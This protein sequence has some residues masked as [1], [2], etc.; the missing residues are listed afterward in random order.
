MLLRA[1]LVP[2]FLAVVADPT[3][4]RVEVDTRETPDLAPWGEQARELVRQWH[5]KISEVLAS[6]GFRPPEEVKIVFK[7]ARKGVAATSGSTITITADW[8][9]KHPDDFGMVVHE[10]THVIQH[11]PPNKANAGWLV[12]GIADHVRCFH[13]EPEKRLPPIDVKKASYRDGYKTAARFLDWVQTK[14]DPRLVSRLNA[15]LR[16]GR[17]HDKLFDEYTGKPLDELWSEFIAAA[18]SSRNP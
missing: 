14:Y 17:Y 16:G 7:D 4:P 2:L 9:R 18:A 11:Y 10:L 8:V 6:D 13:F 5:P 1:L 15:A 12:E 3:A